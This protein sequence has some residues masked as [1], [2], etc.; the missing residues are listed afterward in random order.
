MEQ[1]QAQRHRTQT[2]GH[3]REREGSDKFGINITIYKIVNKDLL[4][5]KED[6]SPYFA[7][8]GKNLKKYV[9]TYIYMTE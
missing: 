9:Y 6:N 7:I 1:K 5:S 2:Y 4:Y 3:Q 8:W